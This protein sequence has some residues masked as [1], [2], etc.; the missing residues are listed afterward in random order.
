MA[1]QGKDQVV[2]SDAK[3]IRA[4]AHPARLTIVNVLYDQGRQITAT[5]AARIAGITPSAMSYHLRAL[6]KAGIIKRADESGDGRE[7]PWVRAAEW[8]NIRADD[9]NST[10]ARTATKAVVSLDAQQHIDHLMAAMDRVDQTND[11]GQPIKETVVYT[12]TSLR[13]TR[14]EAQR[15]FELLSEFVDPWRVERRRDAP[16]AARNIA[17]T[18]AAYT[19]AEQLDDI[20]DK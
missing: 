17:F 7:R 8:L 5:Q 1:E 16:D 9:R 20:L 10:A 12:H 6:E 15:F 4:M 19:E 3:A 2:L 11:P 13:M 14:D 18:I